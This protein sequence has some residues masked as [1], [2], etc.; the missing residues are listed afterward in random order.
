MQVLGI[1]CGCSQ[2]IKD[3]FIIDPQQIVHKIQQKQ[4]TSSFEHPST[5]PAPSQFFSLLFLLLRV[6]LQGGGEVGLLP[7]PISIFDAH[8]ISKIT[9]S[10]DHKQIIRRITQKYFKTNKFLFF[11]FFYAPKSSILTSYR[12]GVQSTLHLTYCLLHFLLLMLTIFQPWIK[13]INR[14][15]NK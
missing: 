1:Y 11:T 15:F 12:E 8:N 14:L 9:F 13:F 5:K 6:S 2:Y 7:V 4:T 10:I 3:N